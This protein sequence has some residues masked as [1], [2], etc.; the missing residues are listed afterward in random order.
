[1]EALIEGNGEPKKTRPEVYT[2]LKQKQIM[3][4]NTIGKEMQGGLSVEA[5]N[6]R[7]RI[8]KCMRE[9]TGR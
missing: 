1:M 6:C 7:K 3:Y 4:R 8:R 9:T 2:S 5:G